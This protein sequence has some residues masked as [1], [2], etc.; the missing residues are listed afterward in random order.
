MQYNKQYFQNNKQQIYE[1]IKS[2][3]FAAQHAYYHRKNQTKPK[4]P[5]SNDNFIIYNTQRYAI[6]TMP[7]KLPY[8]NIVNFI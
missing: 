6:P 2:N 4:L 8:N 3:N 7:P 5:K 1:R